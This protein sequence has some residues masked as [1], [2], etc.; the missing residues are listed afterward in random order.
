ML[1][2]NFFSVARGKNAQK[3][4]LGTSC[5]TDLILL[6]SMRAFSIIETQ[7]TRLMNEN[8]NSLD[9]THFDTGSKLRGW[10]ERI[11]E[12]RDLNRDF[13]WRFWLD[14][15]QNF[16]NSIIPSSSRHYRFISALLDFYFLSILF[17]NTK[18]IILRKWMFIDTSSACLPRTD[19]DVLRKWFSQFVLLLFF[20]KHENV[21]SPLLV[22]RMGKAKGAKSGM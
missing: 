8:V 3:I 6:I 9:T 14:N 22:C 2:K 13:L 19:W 11:D 17:D 7:H 15:L 5:V 10:S 20:G 16:F 21:F 4:A 12:L 1:W 18:R